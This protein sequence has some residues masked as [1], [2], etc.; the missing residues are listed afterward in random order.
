MRRRHLIAVAL[1]ALAIALAAPAGASAAFA[2]LDHPGPKLSVP[3]SKLRSALRCAGSVSAAGRAPILLVPGTSLNP[4]VNFSWNW[5]RALSQRRWNYCTIALPHN[6]MSDIQASGQYLVYAL[7]RLHAR[8]GRRVDVVGYSQGG[9]VPRWALRFWPRTRK[10]V[11]DLIGLSPSN[12]GT[13]DAS[14]ACSRPCAPSFWQQRTGSNFLT[15]LNSRAETFRR[16]SY[17]S[18][19]TNTDEVVVPNAG[20]SAS[21]ALHGKRGRIANVAIQQV[22][23]NDTSDHLAIGSYDNTAFRL[24]IDALTHRGPANPSRV[25]L[26]PC[27]NPFMPGVDRSTFVSDYTH[28]LSY[29]GN[30]I[31]NYPTVPR[32]PRLACYVTASCQA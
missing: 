14:G 17:S 12:H 2:P 24:A 30:V 28:E 19:Y 31:S 6:G 4:H 20:P 9:M 7:R 18:I 5:E 22:C 15:A 11:D 21:S 8:S 27:A 26:A 13:V 32:E 23:P 3:K 16:I 25:N 1:A 29:I 10:M